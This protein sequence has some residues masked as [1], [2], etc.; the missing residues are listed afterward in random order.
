MTFF[1][2]ILTILLCSGTMAYCYVLGKQVKSL[3]NMRDGVGALIEDMIKTTHN[4]QLTFE[5]TKRT[6]D[7]DYER[8]SDKIDEGAI[9]SSYLSDLIQTAENMKNALTEKPVTTPVSKPNYPNQNQN[10]NTRLS[11]IFD[12]QGGN[13][14]DDPLSDVMPKGM[15]KTIKKPVPYIIP[16][17]EYL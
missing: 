6:M 16:G 5:S 2:N 15:G 13:N 11:Q 9:L 14:N 4:L 17:E 3:K 10:I 7:S 1:L 12:S 8:L